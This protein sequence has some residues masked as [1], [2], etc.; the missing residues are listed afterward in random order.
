MV[1]DLRS[2]SDVA[3]YIPCSYC[4]DQLDHIVDRVDEYGRK[5]ARRFVRRR[6][7]FIQKKSKQV[8][9][10]VP[11]K[12]S[13][14]VFK[15]FFKSE[16]SWIIQFTVQVKYS[17]TVAT[18]VN[19]GNRDDAFYSIFKYILWQRR[20][21]IGI[22]CDEDRRSVSQDR[23]ANFNKLLQ[24]IR[25]FK[26]DDRYRIRFCDENVEWCPT[27]RRGHNEA[28]NDADSINYHRDRLNETAFI[29]EKGQY[30]RIIY[31]SRYVD[32][33]RQLLDLR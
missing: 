26:E 9:T 8:H 31:I 2:Q 15:M 19:Y 20:T 5:M 4:G 30:G 33:D 21:V 10:L 6:I 32:P 7:S 29:L 25:I 24:F 22:C 16:I 3:Q 18:A 12:V 1:S 28:F 13:S 17:V 11:E 23:Y 27:K 14:Q